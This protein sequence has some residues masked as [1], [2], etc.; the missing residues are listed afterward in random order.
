MESVKLKNEILCQ[1]LQLLAERS[2]KR[3]TNDLV[4]ISIAMAIIG[5]E[6]TDVAPLK[7]LKEKHEFIASISGQ[8]TAKSLSNKLKSLI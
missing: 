3:N 6:I 5:A 4:I 2:V 7:E 1:Q 8:E